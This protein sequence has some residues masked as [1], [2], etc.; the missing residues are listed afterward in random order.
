MSLSAPDQS[1]LSSVLLLSSVA[2]PFDYPDYAPVPSSS[3]IKPSITILIKSQSH[4]HRYQLFRL[5]P[6]SLFS[7]QSSQHAIPPSV[8]SLVFQEGIP[9]KIVRSSDVNTIT[10]LLTYNSFVVYRVTGTMVGASII[11]DSSCMG[12]RF[13]IGYK[14][15]NQRNVFVWS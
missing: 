6:T 3:T 11:S 4:L 10:S 1:S 7:V 5:I 15:Q 2:D 14:L 8:E 13:S 9:I 12:I